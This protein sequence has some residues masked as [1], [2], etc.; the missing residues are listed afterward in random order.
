MRIA[1]LDPSLSR[2][3]YA[4]PEHGGLFS[5]TA[6]AGPEDP[7]RRLAELEQMVDRYLRLYPPLPDLVVIE[8][9]AYGA[10]QNREI[11]GEI[12]GVIRRHLFRLDVRYVVVAP[13]TLKRFATGAGNADKFRMIAAAER[14]G[15]AP[16]NH[17][18]ADAFHLRRIGR[19]AHGLLGALEAHEI[20]ALANAEVAW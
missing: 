19:A 11:L 7:A 14:L 6:H 2:I 1:G 18:E 4:A 20:D 3:G 5:L 17:D 15:A 9:Y 13:P 8:G 10:K 16:A 12:G